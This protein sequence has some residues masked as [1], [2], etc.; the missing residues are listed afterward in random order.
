[1]LEKMAPCLAK[2][3]EIHPGKESPNYEKLKKVSAHILNQKR[4]GPHDKF[5]WY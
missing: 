2:T 1:M 4:A 5:E 3:P